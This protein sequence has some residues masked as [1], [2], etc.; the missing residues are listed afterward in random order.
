MSPN[1][2]ERGTTGGVTV[3][4]FNELLEYT[5]L[6]HTT[7]LAALDSVRDHVDGCLLLTASAGG[8]AFDEHAFERLS[9]RPKGLYTVVDGKIEPDHFEHLE[10]LKVDIAVVRAALFLPGETKEEQR[11]S[12]G[13]LAA[14]WVHNSS[15]PTKRDS[16][17]ICCSS[18]PEMSAN[19]TARKP[20]RPRKWPATR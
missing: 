8:G 1:M 14:S 7:P 13:C 18:F 9:C 15:L 16:I 2:L 17:T 10:E 3:E 20:L 12:P 6:R 11:Y 19:G 4:Q 5:A